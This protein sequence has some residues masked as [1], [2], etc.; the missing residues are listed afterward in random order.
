MVL[1]VTAL[2]LSI[3]A[4]QRQSP[5]ASGDWS[6]QPAVLRQLIDEAT[7]LEV[8]RL[9]RAERFTWDFGSRK[10]TVSEPGDWKHDLY[11]RKSG[12]GEGILKYPVLAQYVRP[13]ESVLRELREVLQGGSYGHYSK[14][15]GPL[16]PSVAYRFVSARG[17]VELLIC[18]GCREADLVA[19]P[20]VHRLQIDTMWSR[21]LRIAL[22]TFP[23]DPALGRLLENPDSHD[24]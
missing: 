4:G 23:F 1:Q 6:E 16:R 2:L 20:A 5:H 11:G 18:F 14:L 15:C 17:V 10:R 19:G 8:F 7:S 9:G 3:A 24:D 13:P 21:L 22:A 12:S